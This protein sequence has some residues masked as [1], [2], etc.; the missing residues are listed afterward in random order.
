MSRRRPGSRASEPEGGRKYPWVWTGAQRPA[1]RAG[2]RCAKIGKGD[3]ADTVRVIFEDGSD[4]IVV[5]GGL[6]RAP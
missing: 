2:R 5:R 3:T 1:G 6:K 4:F